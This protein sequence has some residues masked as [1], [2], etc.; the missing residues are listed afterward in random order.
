MADARV[1]AAWNATRGEERALAEL[2]TR[3]QV[4]PLLAD[5]RQSE[6]F[7]Y[8]EVPRDEYPRLQDRVLQVRRVD[9]AEVE[10]RLEEEEEDDDDEAAAEAEA[11][12]GRAEVLARVPG[13]DRLAFSY[14]ICRSVK[15]DQ[16]EARV[17][18][19]LV[20]MRG[21]SEALAQRGQPPSGLAEARLARTLGQLLQL[22]SE[23]NHHS[24][25]LYAPDIFWNESLL[26]SLFTRLA[27]HL[28]LQ[29]R[30]A[31]INTRLDYA[32]ELV[33]F[34]I[35]IRNDEAMAH[36]ERIVIFLIA[37]EIITAFLPIPE[38]RSFVL[39]H[40]HQIVSFLSSFKL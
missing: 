15:V 10:E 30:I 14:A 40:Y 28:D 23:L 20:E 36:L 31:R 16:L 37:S 11:E 7:E 17:E 12:E 22:R 18:A 35:R 29:T 13:S 34:L 25:L 24:G 3:F 8:L 33:D 19:V 1:Y 21:W 5:E 4:E 39:T 27:Q 26:E 38:I 32:K 2:V 6:E 9:E